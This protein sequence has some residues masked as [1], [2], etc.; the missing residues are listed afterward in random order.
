MLLP[1]SQSDKCSTE[2]FQEVQPG[3]G[4]CEQNNP[5]SQ[6]HRKYPGPVS[7]SQC[8]GEDPETLFTLTSLA[9]QWSFGMCKGKHISPVVS[10]VSN[11]E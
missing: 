3:S 1:L 2:M 7:A 11:T 9:K 10:N 5:S 8:D 6:L 4:L